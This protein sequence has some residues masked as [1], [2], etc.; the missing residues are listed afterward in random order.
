MAQHPLA[1]SASLV[2][3]PVM[4]WLPFALPT[5]LAPGALAASVCAKSPPL[6]PVEPVEPAAALGEAAA[7]G[8]GAAEELPEEEEEEEEEETKPHPVL[9]C[10]NCAPGPEQMPAGP[11]QQ[12]DWQSALERQAPVMNWPPWPL[13]MFLLPDGSGVSGW[14]MAS[15]R[16]VRARREKGERRTIFARAVLG[17]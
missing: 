15:V 13:P 11:A 10:W 17:V 9:P 5:L 3:A 1:Q 6:E 16:A 8:A 12:A 2:H 7:G 14:G 4:N